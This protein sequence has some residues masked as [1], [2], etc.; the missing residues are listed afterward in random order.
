MITLGA[1]LLVC[2]HLNLRCGAYRVKT[3][4][5]A[6]VHWRI[7]VFG[8][9]LFILES[10]QIEFMHTAGFYSGGGEGFSDRTAL[11]FAGV[12]VTLAGDYDDVEIYTGCSLAALWIFP[13][14]PAAPK[15]G[16]VY[17]ERNEHGALWFP[18]LL[19]VA[20]VRD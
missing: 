16:P 17:Q 8:S 15:L 2:A 12:V 7:E 6:A 10:T 20:G 9:A 19:I 18:V 3:R 4:S 13:L 14:F 1:M 5:A 11:D